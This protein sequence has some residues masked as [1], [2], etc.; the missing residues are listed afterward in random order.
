MWPRGPLKVVSVEQK[1]NSPPEGSERAEANGIKINEIYVAGGRNITGIGMPLPVKVSASG[2]RSE[3]IR[4]A[5][6]ASEHA[7]SRAWSTRIYASDYLAF[8]QLKPS[9]AAKK[10]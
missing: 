1:I 10:M 2:A 3:A 6:G 9:S 4:P 5:D 7:T 8:K